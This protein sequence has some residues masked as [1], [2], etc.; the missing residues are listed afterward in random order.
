[1]VFTHGLGWAGGLLLWSV[2][3]TGTTDNLLR[4]FFMRG[5]SDIH[6]LLLFFA[7]FGGM[8]W[9]GVTGVLVGPVVIAFFLTLAHILQEH[10]EEENGEP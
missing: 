5:S 7:V 8:Y 4:P 6:P 2:T 10:L 9:M 1:M 3:V